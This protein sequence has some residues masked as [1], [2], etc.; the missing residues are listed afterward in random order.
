LAG[1]L[2]TAHRAGIVHGDVKPGNI[3]INPENRVRLGDFGIARLTTQLSLTSRVVGTPA[4]MAPEQIESE[5][6]DHRSDQVFIRRCSLPDADGRPSLRRKV[7]WRGLRPDFEP[8]AA[9]PSHH[10]RQCA[11]A[12]T[13]SLARCL[14]KKSPGTFRFLRG[15]CQVSPSLHTLAAAQLRPGHDET[16]LGIFCEAARHDA[17]KL[18]GTAGLWCEGGAGVW[19]KIWAQ[20]APTDFPSK[21]RTPVSIW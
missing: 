9:P 19:F 10:I 13:A 3:F 6:Q 7:R 2:A 16:F 11:G 12:W 8:Y 4:Y 18:G 21:G 17:V 15:T 1:A 14:R 20:T 5:L